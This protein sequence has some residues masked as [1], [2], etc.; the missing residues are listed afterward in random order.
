MALATILGEVMS[1]G[2]KHA[3]MQGFGDPNPGFGL[4]GPQNHFAPAARTVRRRLTIFRT[5]GD[6]N[7]FALDAARSP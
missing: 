4:S 2:V 5:A 3:R 6:K 7:S 1:Q